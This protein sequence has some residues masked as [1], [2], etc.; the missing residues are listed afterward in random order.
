MNFMSQHHSNFIEIDISS[1]YLRLLCASPCRL[2]QLVRTTQGRTH[3]APGKIPK[4][5]GIKGGGGEGGGRKAE[6]EEGLTPS[7]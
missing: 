6:E 7:N 1:C 4:V 3:F 2:T 5:Q